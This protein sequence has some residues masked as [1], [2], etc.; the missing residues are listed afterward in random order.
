MLHRVLRSNS[1][2]MIV[3]EHAVE[4]VECFLCDQA[5][6]HVVDK[7]VPGLLLVHAEDVVVVAVEGDVV[8][9]NIIE[10]IIRTQNLSDFNQLVVV[11]FSL[12]ERLFLKNHTSK[13][14]PK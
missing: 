8:L 6:I 10:Q 12:E 14:A 4:E 1:L 9:L 3:S 7:L 13:H 2:S 11:I 5:L